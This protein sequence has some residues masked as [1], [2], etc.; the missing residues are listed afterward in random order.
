M[1]FLVELYTYCVYV[2]YIDYI[3]VKSR[4]YNPLRQIIHVNIEV[5]IITIS[6]AVVFA[7]PT[8]LLSSALPAALLLFQAFP[9]VISRALMYY[10]R[11]CL[12]HTEQDSSTLSTPIKPKDNNN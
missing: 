1:K 2:Q 9:Q 7:R 11:A 4:D 6:I 10:T 8:L 3:R 5:G 12:T